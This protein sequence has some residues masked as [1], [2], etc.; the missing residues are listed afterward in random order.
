[1]GI[2]YLDGIEATD[3]DLEHY[4]R[5][6]MKWYQHRF[7]EVDG[8]AKYQ[9]KHG[10]KAEKERTKTI[11]NA[12]KQKAKY[13]KKNEKKVTEKREKYIKNL[14]DTIEWLKTAKFE[15]LVTMHSVKSSFGKSMFNQILREIGLNNERLN[16]TYEL[17]NLG[18]DDMDDFMRKSMEWHAHASMN[19]SR[20]NHW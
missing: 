15:D 19:A 6:G 20:I 4:G 17:D 10:A 13:E 8:R 3:E 18:Y 16:T 14:Q 5:L 9:E 11:A 12:E 2:G 1:M 7:G